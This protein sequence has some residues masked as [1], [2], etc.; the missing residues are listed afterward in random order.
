MTDETDLSPDGAESTAEIE[1]AMAEARARL[2]EVPAEVV[3]VN[4][5]M[6]LY[7]LGAIHLSSQT[8]DLVAA[9]LAIDSMA[10][11]VEGLGER[12]GDDAQTMADA[13]A[14]IRMAFVS[15]KA[16]TG[17]SATNDD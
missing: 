2:A 8:P 12:L 11:L 13:L 15:V 5:I 4:H 9:Q 6:G 10:L 1:A 7:E 17:Q 3:V 14:N 16:Q